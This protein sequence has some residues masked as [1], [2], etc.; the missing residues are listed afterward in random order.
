MKQN[1]LLVTQQ[2]YLFALNFYRQIN[3]IVKFMGDD[4]ELY[5][6][7]KLTIDINEIKAY[8]LL[9]DPNSNVDLTLIIRS[10]SNLD[11]GYQEEVVQSTVNSL[12]GSYCTIIEVNSL[13][14][15]SICAVDK[16]LNKK[17]NL[18]NS[19][20]YEAEINIGDILFVRLIEINGH[21]FVLSIIE[22]INEEIETLFLEKVDKFFKNK[23]I[24]VKQNKNIK[25]LIPLLKNSLID[26]FFLF[27]IS[28]KEFIELEDIEVLNKNRE[29]LL[30]KMFHEKD[31]MIVDKFLQYARVK[32]NIDAEEFFYYI[33]A[34]YRSQFEDTEA[35]YSTFSDYE[36]GKV[37]E[38]A[39]RDG[40]VYTK[41]ELYRTISHLKY[42]YEYAL[43]YD[44]K[45]K[46]AADELTQ[47]LNSFFY[48]NDIMENS[49][50]N[51]Y[52]DED[53]SDNIPDDM[54]IELLDY[55]DNFLEFFTLYNV[56]VSKNSKEITPYFINLIADELN[57]KPI[58]EVKTKR[59]IHYPLIDLFFNFSLAKNIIQIKED[60]NAA[61]LTERI[62]HFLSFE[63]SEQYAIFIHSIFNENFLLSF[64]KPSTVKKLGYTIQSIAQ[65]LKEKNTFII[66]DEINFNKDNLYIIELISN[67]NIIN[68][69]N[70]IIKKT[71]L[72]DTLIDYYI[73]S[74]KKA[75]VIELT[76]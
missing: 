7:L 15:N 23:G 63:P 29:A 2:K 60:S 6:F 44:E 42:F 8:S 24:I 53:I 67:L 5:N 26:I 70:N 47:C 56:K 9:D 54:L 49:L 57:L 39:A 3:N 37:L 31:R 58:K 34:L 71:F 62:N 69:E 25:N 41:V 65:L 32:Y 61:D 12:L 20:L 1:D 66:L 22:T 51:F 13:D 38:N 18:E 64:L 75:K 46:K 76:I 11:Y 72:S 16:F 35:S 28:Y 50:N 19:Q 55:Y 21:T 68:F 36:F 14:E 4:S 52:F 40:F 48:Y 59:Q 17:L 45:Y 74:S 27:S 33:S 10:F 43:R 73:K 30:R